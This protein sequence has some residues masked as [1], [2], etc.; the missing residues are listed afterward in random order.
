MA[1]SAQSQNVDEN[2]FFSKRFVFAENN[3]CPSQT[4]FDFRLTYLLT[5]TKNPYLMGHNV[6]TMQ[7]LK[8]KSH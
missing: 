2:K 6:T 7:N 3:I 4:S 1:A 5:D 8:Y